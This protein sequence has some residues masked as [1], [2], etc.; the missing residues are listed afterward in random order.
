MIVLAPVFFRARKT[1]I[2]T[3]DVATAGFDPDSAKEPAGSALSIDGSYVEDDGGGGS[4]K[5]VANVAE[6][7]VLTV[8]VVGV[9]QHHLDKAT[10][11][12]RQVE[13]SAEAGKK[14]RGVPEE[15]EFAAVLS[16]LGDGLV[17]LVRI[18]S[19]DLAELDAAEE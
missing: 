6:D 8:K 2:E 13:A 1:S 16:A 15:A 7:V 14:R 5:L 4:E 17:D 10:F 3:D 19:D 18:A 11:F 12:E 9:H